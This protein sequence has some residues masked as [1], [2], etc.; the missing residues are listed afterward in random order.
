[1]VWLIP[2]KKKEIVCGYCKK[3]YRIPNSN[4]IAQVPDVELI[5]SLMEQNIYV[6]F[7]MLKGIKSLK[8][9]DSGSHVTNYP[10]LLIHT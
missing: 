2:R 9:F 7:K 6:D 10:G 4:S 8:D 1:M 3:Y 5:S